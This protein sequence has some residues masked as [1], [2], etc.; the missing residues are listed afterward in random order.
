MPGKE[1]QQ[2]RATF[3]L[4]HFDENSQL[5]EKKII[6]LCFYYVFGAEFSRQGEI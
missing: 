4:S 2:L 3:G 1:F 5:I 6:F